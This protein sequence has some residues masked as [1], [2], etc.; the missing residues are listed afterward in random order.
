[1]EK[2]DPSLFEPVIDPATK[3]VET[4]TGWVDPNYS[5]APGATPFPACW[6]DAFKTA[7][8]ASAAPGAS[9]SAPAPSGS[10]PAASG[11]T[12]SGAP[13]GTT[14]D[15]NALN[16]A[17]DKTDV[18]APAN[19]P[20]TIHFDNQDQS[21]QHNIVIKDAAGNQVFD[22]ALITGPSATDYAVP[23]LQPG[24][25]TFVCIVHANMTGTIKAGS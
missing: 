11:A 12:A 8:P 25:Y 5:P 23:A 3:Q 18:T 6:T 14:I 17:F 9:A 2:L 7:A 4:F 16:I 10:A 22:G 1:Y 21:V 15:I 20:F 24:S 19:A 13:S